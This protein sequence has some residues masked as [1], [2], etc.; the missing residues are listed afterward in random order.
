MNPFN[1]MT[2]YDSYLAAIIAK[3]N[4]SS[5]VTLH[6]VIQ[7]LKDYLPSCNYT[8]DYTIILKAI[9][10]HFESTERENINKIIY[11]LAKK[12]GIAALSSIHVRWIYANIDS[13]SPSSKK[14][15][16]DY[17]NPSAVA[18]EFENFLSFDDPIKDL[19]CFKFLIENS[20]DQ[21]YFSISKIPLATYLE[22]DLIGEIQAIN[23]RKHPEDFIERKNSKTK[24]AKIFNEVFEALLGVNQEILIPK[25]YKIL[26]DIYGYFDEKVYSESVHLNPE[27]LKRLVL[28]GADPQR[29]SVKSLDQLLVLQSF[30]TDKDNFILQ[31]V[32]TSMCIFALAEGTN[33]SSFFIRDNADKLKSVAERS[34][35]MHFIT[36]TCP[37]HG[38]LQTGMVECD[39]LNAM[40]SILSGKYKI[41]SASVLGKDLNASEFQ[42]QD[43]D[44]VMEHSVRV[45]PKEI[46][47]KNKFS[48]S[49]LHFFKRYPEVL[50]ELLDSGKIESF[51][52]HFGSTRPEHI[53]RHISDPSILAKYLSGL[54]KDEIQKLCYLNTSPALKTVY[55]FYLR[56]SIEQF[57][58]DYTLVFEHLLHPDFLIYLLR[59]GNNIQGFIFTTV[60][61]IRNLPF[62]NTTLYCE[63]NFDIDPELYY[64]VGLPERDPVLK[65]LI[66]VLSSVRLDL[67]LEFL[68]QLI[69]FISHVPVVFSE[70]LK[71]HLRSL[72]DEIKFRSIFDLGD[73]GFIVDR[74]L[75]E[76]LSLNSYTGNVSLDTLKINRLKARDVILRSISLPLSYMMQLNPGFMSNKAL[77]NVITTV[78]N[79]NNRENFSSISTLVFVGL[80]DVKS[81]NLDS[82]NLNVADPTDRSQPEI[83]HS[84]DTNVG[85]MLANI[86]FTRSTSYSFT[87]FDYLLEAD[88]ILHL[89]EF[90]SERLE[91]YE[92]YLK[93]ISKHY[94]EIFVNMYSISKLENTD[95]NAVLDL[96][97]QPLSHLKR[98]FW[99]I[100]SRVLFVTNNIYISFFIEKMLTRYLDSSTSNFL[101][102]NEIIP[103]MEYIDMCNDTE[104]SH[105]AFA[106]PNMYCKFNI[107]RRLPLEGCIK[108]LIDRKIDNGKMTYSGSN[109]GHKIKFQYRADSLIHEASI[110]IPINFPHKHAKI[111]FD[112]SSKNMKFYHQ[113]NEILGRTSKFVEIFIVW[114]I[115]IDNRLMGYNECLICYFIMDPMY[116]TLPEFKCEVCNNSFHKKCIYK[117]AAETRKPLCP[118]C[119]SDLPL[120][121]SKQ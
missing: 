35:N 81:L 88:E 74:V 30:V 70:R 20:D 85:K 86:F 72:E 94:S 26:L 76:R 54:S 103:V 42:I 12:L 8:T 73:K 89:P 21:H 60:T 31:N 36:R 22:F 84:E 11:F 113:L 7:E 102:D 51:V 62:K 95:D 91:I 52:S 96:I 120:W 53:A 61:Y 19:K 10:P 59:N 41:V 57:D 104:L 117:W 75:F 23:K 37:N 4:K 28:E 106:F 97:L 45:F 121:V 82:L 13:D 25:K 115:D 100:V 66:S 50:K 65:L 29:L 34:I 49:A 69:K 112:G 92:P 93:M 2:K 90:R 108:A 110:S 77:Q 79:Q 63:Y 118:F 5:S 68:M 40:Y 78:C 111:E 64:N 44:E 107:K 119:R 87:D 105:F 48:S 83:T 80:E 56:N 17:F 27:I 99:M 47:F 33:L 3:I 24:V 43:I 6:V 32:N 116:K 46:F 101:N 15:L 67:K 39:I 18:N 98:T 9:Q 55:L 71:K 114:K 16:H 109:N 58:V 14:L 38:Q 1:S